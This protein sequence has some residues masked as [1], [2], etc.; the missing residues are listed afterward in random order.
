MFIPV[1]RQVKR[2]YGGEALSGTVCAIDNALKVICAKTPPLGTTWSWPA[3]IA[4]DGETGLD[5][6]KITDGGF[7]FGWVT[8]TFDGTRFTRIQ[9]RRYT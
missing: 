6:Y 9:L 4:V 5:W 2:K 3:S 7:D 8:E 1:L